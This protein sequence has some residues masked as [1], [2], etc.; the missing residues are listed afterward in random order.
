MKILALVGSVWGL[1]CIALAAAMMVG[2]VGNIYDVATNP[3]D[4][5]AGRDVLGVAGVAVPPLG[6]LLWWFF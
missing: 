1:F 4:W 5:D 2:W 3:I 6:G